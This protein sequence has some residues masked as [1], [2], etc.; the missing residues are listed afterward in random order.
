[1]YLFIRRGGP[2]SSAETAR[3]SEGVTHTNTDVTDRRGS[4]CYA[5]NRPCNRQSRALQ[6]S[7]VIKQT[8][9]TATMSCMD[10]QTS[11]NCSTTAQ[12]CMHPCSVFGFFW[13][14]FLVHVRVQF[15]YYL[16]VHTTM[17][18]PRIP[19]QPSHHHY[20]HRHR[21]NSL[22]EYIH[23]HCHATDKVISIEQQLHVS[24]SVDMYTALASRLHISDTLLYSYKLMASKMRCI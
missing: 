18:R 23:C 21:R 16:N 4:A 11:Y 17:R 12:T 13:V 6:R 8:A 1:M 24:C 2:S 22:A 9:G 10:G 20:L 14:H 5:C 19:A 15:M 7:H 3:H